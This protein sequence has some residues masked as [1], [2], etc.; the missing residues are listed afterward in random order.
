MSI[1]IYAADAATVA[2]MVV[3]VAGAAPGTVSFPVSTGAEPRPVEK[4]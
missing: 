2:T 4:A 1:E 3:V